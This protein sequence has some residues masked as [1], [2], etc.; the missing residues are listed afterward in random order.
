GLLSLVF[1]PSALLL[2]SAAG[3]GDPR[4]TSAGAA[5]EFE[6]RLGLLPLGG[7]DARSAALAPLAGTRLWLSWL[8]LR[9]DLPG[10]AADPGGAGPFAGEAVAVRPGAEVGQKMALSGG[11]P[12]G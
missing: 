2:A 9:A 12:A 8:A 5:A 4:G 1:P 11:E 10:G 3:A 6:L 7:L